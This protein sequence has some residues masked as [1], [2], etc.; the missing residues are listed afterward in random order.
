[1]YYLAKSQTYSPLKQ[2]V[3]IVTLASYG[4]LNNASPTNE[5]ANQPTK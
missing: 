2:V 5:D 3:Y 1:M 4:I